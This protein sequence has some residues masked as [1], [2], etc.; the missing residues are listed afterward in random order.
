MFYIK[1]KA[2]INVYKV[3]MFLYKKYKVHIYIYTHTHILKSE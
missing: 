1:C 3:Y 2:C